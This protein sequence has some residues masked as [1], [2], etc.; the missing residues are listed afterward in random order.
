MNIVTI[1]LYLAKINRRKHKAF[2]LIST[3]VICLVF[4][5]LTASLIGYAIC[6]R[7]GETP[8]NEAYRT[9]QETKLECSCPI[10]WFYASTFNHKG[11][12]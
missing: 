12:F 6:K 8:S 10:E 5:L 2:P 7:G 3:I 9:I 1:D 4:L 11:G